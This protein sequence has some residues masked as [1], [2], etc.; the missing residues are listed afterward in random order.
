MTRIAEIIRLT[1]TR[2]TN[3]QLADMALQE[4]QAAR[5]AR[6]RGHYDAAREH[7]A[8]ADQL[9]ELIQ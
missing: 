8:C 5:A 3:Q 4:D 9:A 6:A 2:M 1:H 7:Q